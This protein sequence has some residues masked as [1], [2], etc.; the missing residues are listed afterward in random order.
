MI[1]N[2]NNLK[3]LDFSNFIVL[4]LKNLFLIL[5]IYPCFHREKEREYKIR[6]DVYNLLQT[7]YAISFKSAKNIAG[8]SSMRIC[9]E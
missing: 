4:T 6:L 2:L 5:F 7:L 9:K 1:F 8:I 3:K